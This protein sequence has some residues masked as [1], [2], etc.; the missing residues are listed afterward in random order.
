MTGIGAFG[1]VTGAFP[2]QAALRCLSVITR[3]ATGEPMREFDSRPDFIDGVKRTE[4]P[5]LSR[6]FSW[7]LQNPGD[8]VLQEKADNLAE[9]LS[10]K[11]TPLDRVLRKVEEAFKSETRQGMANLE[12]AVNK[13][14]KGTGIS[15][16]LHPFR[17]HKTN[18]AV[19]VI[20]LGPMPFT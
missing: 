5:D 19:T 15:L 8:R 3:F 17:N 16:D 12:A 7:N 20:G 14:L 9:V 18:M 4:L 13:K 11:K 6:E 2:R 1:G 10:D